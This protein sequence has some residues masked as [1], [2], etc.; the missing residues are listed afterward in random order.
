M[1]AIR[2]VWLFDRTVPLSSRKLSRL[3]SISMSDGTSGLSRKKWILSNPISTTWVIPLASW[4]LFGPSPV[5][6]EAP[7]APASLGPEAVG[8]ALDVP[9]TPRLKSA[10]RLAANTVDRFHPRP[11]KPSLSIGGMLLV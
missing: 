4:Q 9:V 6:N 10:T 1:C 11:M 7:L 3:G 8:E 5:P 2:G